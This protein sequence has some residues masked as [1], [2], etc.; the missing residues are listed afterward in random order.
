[1]T[2]VVLFND[3]AGAVATIP[4]RTNRL[5]VNKDIVVAA[6]YP[7]MSIKGKVWTLVK[8]AERRTLTKVVDGEEEVVQAITVAML[9]INLGAK[10]YYAKKFDNDDSEGARPD[11]HTMDGITPSPQSPNKQANKCAICPHNQWGSRVSD[12]GVSKGKACSDHARVAI[13]DPNALDKAMLLRVP[14][15]SLKP[16][17]DA[18]K[19]MKTRDLQY[20]EGVYRISFDKDAASPKLVIKPIGLLNDAGYEKAVE[21]FDGELVRAIAGIDEVEAAAAAAPAPKADEVDANELDAALAGR[22]AVQKAA[23]TPAPAPKAK[24]A[25]VDADELAAVVEKKAPA[26]A[27]RPAPAPKPT[28]APAPAPEPVATTPVDMTGGDDL[29]AEMGAMLG[30][31]DD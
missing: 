26:P 8:D 1:M 20:N 11:C 28:P 14:P 5:D 29:L 7:T 2:N 12:D 24:V 19:M 10:V 22:K 25:T 15:A 6:Q 17:K 27:P 31:L 21:L 9:R 3:N 13:A 16:L 23:A 4:K 18:L 30:M